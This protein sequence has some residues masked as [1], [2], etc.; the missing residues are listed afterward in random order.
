M[1]PF[2]V[3]GSLSRGGSRVTL[4]WP[5]GWEPMEYNISCA[6]LD[7][8]RPSWTEYFLDIAKVVATR[9]DCTRRRVGAVIVKDNRI[10]STGYNGAPSGRPG[11]A[12]QGACPRGKLTVEEQPRDTGYSNCGAVHAEANAI[13]YARKDLSGATLYCT[14]KPCVECEKL[15]AATGIKEVVYGDSRNPS[16]K[17]QN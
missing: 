8:P 1:G 14:D 12:S 6:I 17:K 16:T 7:N 3:T 13:I 10:L 11:C 15:I 4:Y 9:A 5:V 2:P